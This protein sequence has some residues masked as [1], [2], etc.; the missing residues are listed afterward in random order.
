MLPF[1]F[2]V[3][4]AGLGWRGEYALL[5]AVRLYQ[6]PWTERV[7][8]AIETLMGGR[9]FRGCYLSGLDCCE[10]LSAWLH[11][12]RGEKHVLRHVGCVFRPKYLAVKPGQEGS[13]A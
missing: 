7:D 10:K 8:V 3:C 6:Q 5:L 13:S 11:C 12:T 4:W 1:S 2:C 9:M